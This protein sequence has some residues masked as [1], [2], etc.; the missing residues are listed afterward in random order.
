MTNDYYTYA[1][2]REDGT[3]YYI[4]KGRGRR[5][6]RPE[7]PSK[8]RVLILKKNITE[9][10]AFRHEVYMISVFGRRDKNTG[11]LH[12]FSDG[13]DGAS[14]AVRSPETRAK[15]SEAKKGKPRPDLAERNRQQKGVP[16]G[17]FT[18]EHRRNLSIAN[19]NRA[20]F[21]EE[22]RRKMS[23]SAKLRAADPEEK[24]RR[25]ARKKANPSPR[26]PNGQFI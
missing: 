25:S 10:E 24:A 9:A 8:D 3:P 20:P 14:G 21:S 17:P 7:G 15:M 23:E 4:G 18:D 13:G 11:I 26:G 1:W 2:L 19:K 16:R 5:A 12:N 22:T 6:W